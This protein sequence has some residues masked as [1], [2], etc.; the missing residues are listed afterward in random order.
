LIW[1]WNQGAQRQTWPDEAQRF[2]CT[3]VVRATLLWLRVYQES[4][5]DLF[6]MTPFYLSK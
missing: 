4:Q 1:K 6:H 3:T 5:P 2:A